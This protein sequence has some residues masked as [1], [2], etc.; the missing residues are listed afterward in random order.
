MKN[1]YRLVPFAKKVKFENHI[2]AFNYKDSRMPISHLQKSIYKLI[3]R[4]CNYKV[5]SSAVKFEFHIDNE[6]LP[7]AEITKER[8]LDAEAT[9]KAIKSA[10][11]E[12]EQAQQKKDLDKIVS[13]AEE[14]TNLSSQFYELLPNESFTKQSIPPINN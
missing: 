5:I 6:S 9:L 14:I 10:I 3:R 2:K 13:C 1:K 7:L 4:I 8:L 11:A 12:C